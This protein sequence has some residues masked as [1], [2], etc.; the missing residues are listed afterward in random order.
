M[1]TKESLINQLR[2]I[3][4]GILQ[5]TPVMLAYLYGSIA[6]GNAL[7]TS[8]VDIAL[9]LCHTETGSSLLPAERLQL[10]LTVEGALEQFGIRK[11]DVRLIDNLPILFRGQVAL[12]GVRLFSRDEVARVEFETRTWK[13]YLDFEPV[14]QMMR[15]A[16]FKGIQEHGFKLG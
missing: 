11:P 15:Q 10:E 3:L 14:I 13:E 12:Q 16:F 2:Q 9:V 8:D 1:N 4:P 5:D 6:T 7:P